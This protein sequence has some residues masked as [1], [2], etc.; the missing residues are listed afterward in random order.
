LQDHG[1]Y[2][3]RDDHAPATP[4]DRQ[5]PASRTVLLEHTTPDSGVHLDW[6][7][8]RP[9]SKPEHPLIAFRCAHDPLSRAP[10]TGERIADHRALYLD[11]EG[12]I[13]GGRGSVRR[14]WSWPCAVLIET[15]ERIS[16]TIDL[17]L[18]G[19]INA[20]LRHLDRTTWTW[21]VD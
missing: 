21:K 17:G 8:E 6:L 15:S 1:C 16:F 11:Y 18:D 5:I 10:W 9:G 4:G 14:L 7:I 13:S 3:M 2:P 19:T 12:S 20:D